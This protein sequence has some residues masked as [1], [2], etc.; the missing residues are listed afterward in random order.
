PVRRA[1][2]GDGQDR[3]LGSEGVP[4]GR[5]D[6]PRMS[7]RARRPGLDRIIERDG[8]ALALPTARDLDELNEHR[9]GAFEVDPDP[10]PMPFLRPVGRL[11]VLDARTGALL[12][13]VSWVP[14]VHGPT[15]ACEAW[16]IGIT[17]LPS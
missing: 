16:N 10:R 8:V 6:G 12:G 15:V 17:L 13:Q 4:E 7:R 2:P 3:L 11:V 9:D 5:P 1:A 14:I